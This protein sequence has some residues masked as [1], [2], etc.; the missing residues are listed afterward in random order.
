MASTNPECYRLGCR[1]STCEVSCRMCSLAASIGCHVRH[2]S[3]YQSL[4][5]DEFIRRN[6]RRKVITREMYED[7]KVN[8]Y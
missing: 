6:N 1:C 7:L 4:A 2:C 5:Y 3:F 8:P